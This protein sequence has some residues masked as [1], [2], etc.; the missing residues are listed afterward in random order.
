[1]SKASFIT[2]EWLGILERAARAAGGFANLEAKFLQL[3]NSLMAKY[4]VLKAEVDE[5]VA[6]VKGVIGHIGQLSADLAAAKLALENGEDID[7]SELVA[8]LDAAQLEM[9][10]AIKPAEALPPA[11]ETVVVSE[12]TG[13]VAPEVPPTDPAS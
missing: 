2:D 13:E 3:E 11:E 4:E 8:K 12:P 10:S 7:Y 9:A 5:T 1:M 6:A